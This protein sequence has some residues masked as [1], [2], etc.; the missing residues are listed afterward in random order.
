MML[1]QSPGLSLLSPWR[2]A[3]PVPRSLFS[4]PGVMLPQSPVHESPA[5]PFCPPSLLMPR[6]WPLYQVPAPISP[7]TPSPVVVKSLTEKLGSAA[8][9]IAPH[10]NLSHLSPTNSRTKATQSPHCYFI[11]LIWSLVLTGADKLPTPGQ[12]LPTI[13]RAGGSTV[14]S[15]N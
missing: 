11:T 8:F 1:P 6:P 10:D 3:A 7:L 15:D 13:K 2:D 12:S 14:H 9:H 4:L 5:K